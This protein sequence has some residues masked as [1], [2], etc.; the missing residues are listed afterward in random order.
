MWLCCG[1]E[2]GGGVREETLTFAKLSPC[3]QS[4]PLLPTIKLGPPGAD[5]Q[6]GGFVF[7]LGPCGPLQRTLLWGWEFLLLPQHPQVFT[8]RDFK[9]LFPCTGTLGFRGLS[10]FPVVPP[11]LSARKCGT[12]QFSRCCHLT[13]PPGLPVAALL[14]VFSTQTASVCPSYKSAWMFL[15]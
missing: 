2:C 6:V 13:H 10:G 15:L 11:G 7:I 9:A 4:L 14:G 5:S 12:T 8:V 1:A 3:F